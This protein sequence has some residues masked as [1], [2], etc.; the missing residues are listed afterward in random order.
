MGI[1]MHIEEDE[2]DIKALFGVV[3]KHKLLLLLITFVF[4][5]VSSLYAYLQPNIYQATASVKVGLDKG[6]MAK[7][8]LSMAMGKGAV[9]E[10]TEKDLIESR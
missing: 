2:I 8:V 3:Y 4:T 6:A 10:G 7:D 9:T 1:N 5:I